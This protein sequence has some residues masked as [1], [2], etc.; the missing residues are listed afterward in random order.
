MG[1]TVVR[2]GSILRKKRAKSGGA[3]VGR[4]GRWAGR[5]F[6]EAERLVLI[7]AVVTLGGG[8]VVVSAIGCD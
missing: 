1:R 3:R 7:V 4:C 6:S 8:G 2:I 5:R